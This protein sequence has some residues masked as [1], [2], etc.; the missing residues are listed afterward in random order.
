MKRMVWT[1]CM[2]LGITSSLQAAENYKTFPVSDQVTVEKV[3]FKNRYDIELAGDMYLPKG[4]DR[5]RKYPAIIVG[6]PFGAVKEQ[7]SGRYAQEMARRGFV[8]LAFDASYSGESGGTPRLTVSPEADV[9]DFSAAVD[10]MG[11]RPF[12]DRNRIGV[13][14]ICGSGGFVLS[15]AAIDPRMKAVA[16]VSMYDM[17]RVRRQGL[18]DALTLEQRKKNLEAI[19]EQRWKEFEGAE[20]RIQFGTPETL[21]EN[22]SGIAKEFYAYYRTER[23]RHPNYRG[24]RYTSDAALMNFFPFQQIETISPR[25]I[26][27]VVGDHAHSRYFSEDAYKLAAEPKELYVVPDAG[28]V[29]LYDRMDKIPFD[30]LESF[31]RNNLK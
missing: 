30:K 11:T 23:G 22:A 24:T 19:A 29:D 21:P 5:T 31:F 26:L 6:H 25:P 20:P 9:E 17:G 15:A 28:H 27:F 3:R 14:G 1:L 12:V 7:P 18:N 10:F 13:I 8:T 16:T 2:M 4:L